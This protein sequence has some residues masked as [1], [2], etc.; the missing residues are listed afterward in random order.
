MGGLTP[1]PAPIDEKDLAGDIA[2]LFGNK[3]THHFGNLF[4]TAEALQGNRADEGFGL[5]RPHGFEGF[6]EHVRFNRT[7][8]D[9]INADAVDS[10]FLG[11]NPGQG[12]EPAFGSGVGALRA[13]NRCTTLDERLMMTPL[14]R[15]RMEGRT[16]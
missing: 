12:V 7:R 9:G 11:Q 13:G 15:A 4:R 10:L 8:R 5:L 16:A 14:R 1:R 2:R 6:L 3:K